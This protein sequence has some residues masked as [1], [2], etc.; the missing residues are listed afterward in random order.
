MTMLKK[1]DQGKSAATLRKQQLS[2]F[3]HSQPYGQAIGLQPPTE[4]T[5][6]YLM[7]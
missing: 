1:G 5:N 6:R 2:A 3:L 4:L 7:Q